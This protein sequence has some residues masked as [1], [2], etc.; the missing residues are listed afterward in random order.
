M[1]MGFEVTPRLQA[2]P[3]EFVRWNPLRCGGLELPTNLVI[4]AKA[5]AIA[6]LLT[7]HFLLLPDPFLPFV[8]GMDRIP[9]ALFQRSMQVLMVG[10]ALAL[11]CNVRVRLT[12]FLLGMSLLLSVVASKA[13][14]GNNKTFCGLM[15]VLASLHQPGRSPWMLRLQMVVVYFGAGLNKVLD[16]DWRS[17]VF[18]HNWVVN[19][20]HQ[21][22]FIALEPLLPDLLLA[23]LMSWF[24]IITE[25]FLSVAFLVRRLYPLGIWL[26]LLLH[27]GMLLFTG[28]TFTLFFYGMTAAMLVFVDWPEQ[29][30]TVIYDGDCGFCDATR[31]W[32]QKLDLEGGLRWIP[33]RTVPLETFGITQEMAQ[34]RV[35]LVNGDRVLAGFRAFRRMVLHNPAA[36]VV[37]YLVLAAP[38]PGDSTFRN[39]LVAILL[40]LFSPL[41]TPFGEAL[42]RAVARNR[43]RLSRNSQC[44]LPH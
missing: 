27:S 42:Y 9:G 8:P 43:H 34:E 28:S 12:S 7:R 11:L 23:K 29:P 39:V 6:L 10:A 38:G 1:A 37:T 14:Y 3:A 16:P 4:M 26:S 13:Y 35:Y 20:L 32:F 15:L 30:L 25:L 44:A 31:R 24:T 33:S 22:V 21:P 36:Y 18:S 2:Q 41:F 40:I 17:G 19:R 5:I